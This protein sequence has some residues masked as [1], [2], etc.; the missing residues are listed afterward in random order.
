MNDKK[1]SFGTKLTII[2]VILLVLIVMLYVKNYTSG[3]ATASGESK[4]STSK[5]TGQKSYSSIES[6]Q[7]KYNLLLPE[8]ITSFKNEDD[9]LSIETTM[10]QIIEIDSSQ[11][12]VKVMT[13][14]N[15]NADPLALYDSSPVDNMYT[16]SNNEN[17][18]NFFRYRTGYTQY[19]HCTLINYC[20][21]SRAYGILLGTII[22]EE[23]ALN[24]LGIS[25]ESL[26]STTKEANDEAYYNSE[27]S[28]GLSNSSGTEIVTASGDEP[29]IQAMLE[30]DYIEDDEYRYYTIQTDENIIQ[31][32]IPNVASEIQSIKTNSFSSFYLN[33]TCIF[34]I[35]YDDKYSD[36]ECKENHSIIEVDTNK[37]IDYLEVNPFEVDTDAYNDYNT[38]I[39]TIIDVEN[40]INIIKI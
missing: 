3:I 7:S 17:G 18:I 24:Y 21:E 32:K 39:N 6:L 12:V 34:T 35:F 4:Y 13:F 19:E 36:Y 28:D 8:I 27:S 38:I 10:N 9:S 23:E 30:V 22:A 26:V 11:F 14:V 31:L 25:Q 16:V 29:D 40:N 37:F 2:F 20:T 15:N 33:G 5:T 1:S